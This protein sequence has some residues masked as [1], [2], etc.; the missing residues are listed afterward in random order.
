MINL[1][2]IKK[3]IEKEAKF[4]IPLER[5]FHFLNFCLI[6]YVIMTDKG[7]DNNKRKVPKEDSKMGKDI[8]RLEIMTPKTVLAL[9][10]AGIIS[11][12]SPYQKKS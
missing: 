2:K 7:K 9:F 10:T 1:I 12:N 5:S 3:V 11:V 4:I 8:P 6:K